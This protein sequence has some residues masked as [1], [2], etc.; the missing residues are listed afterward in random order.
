MV[1]WLRLHISNAGVK[2]S[3]GWG[4]K[5]SQAMQCRKEKNPY[6]VLD[7]ALVISSECLLSINYTLGPEL[8]VCTYH[9]ISSLYQHWKRIFTINLIYR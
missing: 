4:N 5:I 1:Q 8:R 7:R 2:G 6:I 3:P 9:C